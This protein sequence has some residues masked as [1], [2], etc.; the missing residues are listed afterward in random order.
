MSP[1]TPEMCMKLEQLWRG[2][3]WEVWTDF[4]REVGGSCNP[5]SHAETPTIEIPHA[6]GPLR[7]EGTATMTM[8]GKVM[9]PVLSTTFHARLPESR[10]QRFSVSRASFATT[11][12]TWFGAHDIAVHDEA[13]DRAFVLKGDDPAVVRQIFANETL[14]ARYL[15]DFE[16][17]LHR[18]DDR[19]YLG[20]P[21]PN[22]DPLA[23]VVP[24]YIDDPARL[25][26]LWTLFVETLERVPDV[27]SP[28]G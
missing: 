27:A 24:G 13:F 21:T 2:T 26:A 25:R 18:H 12:A 17:Q 6:S 23:L 4:A 15:R 9:V 28:R 16:G 11:I 14:R 20:D 7:I 10:G 22:A 8:L 1:I 5:P 3:H 19:T